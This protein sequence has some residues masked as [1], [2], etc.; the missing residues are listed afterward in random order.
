M[1]GNETK[2][3]ITAE[4]KASRVVGNVKKELLGLSSVGSRLSGVVSP[5]GAISLAAAGLGVG[6]LAVKNFVGAIDDLNNAAQGAGISAVALADMRIAAQEAGVG[7]Q[8]LDTAFAR[9]N[10]R[11]NEAAGG[12][13]EAQ[14][15]F[16]RVGVSV[17]DA[18]GNLKG[19]EQLIK[20]IADQFRR[21]ADGPEKAAL[22]I[23]LFGRTG[24]KFVAFL[25]QG[26]DGLKRFSGLTEE[27]VRESL[28]LQEE[29]N[30]LSA[31]WEAFKNTLLGSVVP[32]INS[33]INWLRN[34]GQVS[35]EVALKLTEQRIDKLRAQLARTATGTVGGKSIVDELRAEIALRDRL[36]AQLQ[37]E[38][39]DR[40]LAGGRAARGIDVPKP[41][42]GT[43]EDETKKAI[44]DAERFLKSLKDQ[45]VAAGKTAEEVLRLKAAQLGVS[46]A[47]EPYIRQIE[48]VREEA[49][50]LKNTIEF[51][52]AMERE[53]EEIAE[54]TK[55]A[56]MEQERAADALVESV[57]T[58]GERIERQLKKLDELSQSGALGRAA[59]R[60]GLPED[61]VRLRLMVELMGDLNEEVE[62][63]KSIAEE[64]GLTF[65]SAFEDAIVQGKGLRD[66]LRGIEQDILRIITRQLV[67]R[68][69]A[70]ALG[71]ILG[72]VFGGPVHSQY[73][74]FA[75]GGYI[76]PGTWGLVG[77][78]GPEMVFGGRT[79]ANVVDAERSKRMGRAI[80]VNVNVPANT[81]G[82]SAQQ[83]GAAAA[84]ALAIADARFN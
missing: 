32:A 51:L 12:S 3:R 22:A 19:G 5:L 18:N 37:R 16:R 52:T 41:I 45:A 74:K 46:T 26:G 33:T 55:N 60:L 8:D 6:V 73:G 40:F 68:P 64:L 39:T 27:S 36:R 44:S 53:R 14:D 71:G 9:L 77:E 35:D 67:T 58:S 2:I 23:D 43:R 47:A 29:I 49:E 83:I 70:D 78:R 30:K 31:S 17:K 76:Q 28:K 54:R 34:L 75:A 38:A 7:A 79:G 48:K 4:D 15:A 81:S 66:I 82:A 57:L 63:N 11:M 59:L 1:A 13:K 20:E 84:R 25:N 62:K 61:E 72:G 80:T 10:Q 69:L 50:Q 56:Y 24:A 42:P 65:S 21:F